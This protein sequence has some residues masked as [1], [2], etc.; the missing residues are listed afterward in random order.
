MD[1][2]PALSWGAFTF[3]PRTAMAFRF[4]APMT[5]P[6]PQRPWKCFSWLTMA[7][8]RTPRSP[9]IPVWRTRSTGAWGQALAL[10]KRPKSSQGLTPR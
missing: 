7:A 8:K 3:E 6:S 4:L 2:A 5:A 9:E 1:L 10:T